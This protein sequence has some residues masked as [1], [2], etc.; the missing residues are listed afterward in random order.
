[1]ADLTRRLGTTDAVVIGLSS[2]I[3][4]GLFA[5]FAPAAAAA[6]SG[7]LIALAIAA[8]IALCN[9]SSSAA[10]AARYPSA[11]GTYV[12]GR[13]RLGPFWGFLAGWG[14]VIGK[15]ASCAA[16]ALTA[17]TYL[18]P[19]S[20]KPVAV[21]FTV[22]LGGINYAGVTRTAKLA[23]V[24]LTG[25]LA[26][27]ACTLVAIW[28]G[29]GIDPAQVWS[30]P[31]EVTVAGVLQAAGLLFFA[32]A[33]YARIATLGEEVREPELTIPRAIPIALGLV[34]GL[35]ALVGVTLLAGMGP[36]GLAAAAAPLAAAVRDGTLAGLAPVAVAG[37]GI[38]ALGALLALLA[39]VGRT[40]LAMAR[41]RDLPAGL[42]AVH[43]RFST[44]HRAEALIIVVVVGLILL[45][46]LR[47]AIGFS[48][49]GVLV[50]Y[51]IANAAAFTLP[52][53][54]RWFP[55]ALPVVGFAGCV[56]LAFSLPGQAVLSGSACFAIGAVLW[57]VRT[58]LARTGDH[59]PPG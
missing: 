10:L 49:F 33:G 26:A 14:F 34:V 45:T 2:M 8:L 7:V 22:L 43:P 13:K 38:A 46:D 9:A 6:G 48:S 59:T 21:V 23:R 44:P 36:D 11:G 16:M 53:S 12:Y 27:L 47:G 29:G 19:H 1:M 25:T 52:R 37:A 20:P 3:G 39:G 4:A 17:A 18:V 57:L 50:Y 5:A 28:F 35:Y 54:Q 42:A 32:F 31:P 55:L 24:L 41:G 15:T 30:S 58:R 51:A 56:A 40:T